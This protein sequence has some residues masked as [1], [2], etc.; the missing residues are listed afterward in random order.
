MLASYHSELSDPS[1]EITLKNIPEE[2]TVLRVYLTDENNDNTLEREIKITEKTLALTL[3]LS[4][5][6]I[7]LIAAE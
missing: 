6:Q 1:C 5:E 3:T 7:R 4:D 2:A